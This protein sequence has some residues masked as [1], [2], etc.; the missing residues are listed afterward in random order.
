MKLPIYEPQ[1][2]SFLLRDQVL[3]YARGRVLD[4]GTGSG[5]QA[6]AASSRAISVLAVDINPYAL[7]FAKSQATA[8][9]A[10]NIKF[11]KSDLFSNIKEKFNL[12]IF[13]PPYLPELKGEPKRLARQISGGKK[14]YEILERFLSQANNHL[15]RDGQILIVFSSQTKKEKVD[16]IIENYGF[17]FTIISTSKIAFETLY[18]YLIGRSRFLKELTDL[19]FKEIKKFA[20][21]HRG[22][23]YT[24][25]V[26]NKKIAIKTKLPESAAI[27][28]IERE[29]EWLRLL[30]K[31]GIGPKL[32][33]IDKNFFCYGFAEG[34]LIKD[35]I[36]KATKPKIKKVLT[37]ILKQCF[38]LDQMKINKEEMHHPVKHIIIGKK[39]ILIDAKKS[40]TSGI[41]KTTNVVLIDFERASKSLKPHNI[42]QFCQYIINQRNILNKKGF[43]ISKD[44]IIKLAKL[45]K[46]DISKTNLNN[47]I[48]QLNV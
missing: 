9:K 46:E 44:K 1:E 15:E 41:S 4:I 14:G 2:D 26:K 39:V 38:I 7:T 24:A 35:F 48:K 10:K 32:L 3:K 6:I 12:I 16:E 8:L 42:S 30:N 28:N 27:G 29:A 22:I 17:N 34:K 47:I 25:K 40:K 11:R 19:G 45:Y 5:I 20:K 23:I 13:N 21:G 43:K 33:F 31:K 36:P 37:E 18:V